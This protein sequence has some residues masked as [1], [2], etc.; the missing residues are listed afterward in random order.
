[1]ADVPVSREE[2]LEAWRKRCFLD[3]LPEDFLRVSA[4]TTSSTHPQQPISPPFAGHQR[5]YPQPHH[6]GGHAYG[7][8][9]GRGEHFG[10]IQGYLRITVQQVRGRYHRRLLLD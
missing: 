7:A 2:R 4:Q 5:P 3:Q 8:Q 9:F 10:D 6:G 1:M